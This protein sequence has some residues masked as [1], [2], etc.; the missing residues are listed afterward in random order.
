MVPADQN[1]VPA[2]PVGWFPTSWCAALV[3]A[4]CT[5]EAWGPLGVT[6]TTLAPF[7]RGAVLPLALGFHLPWSCQ[8]PGPTQLGMWPGQ[9]L[10]LPCNV[11]GLTPGLAHSGA[12]QTQD[13]VAR[14]TPEFT[15]GICLFASAVR[16]TCPGPRQR[17]CVGIRGQPRLREEGAVS[18][19]FVPQSTE[20]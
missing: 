14:R 19:A 17:L 15:R 16:E 3:H 13:R 18:G 11:S 1:R 7:L 2:G 5:A 8:S 4:Y 9:V 10:L 12:S 20:S 6:R